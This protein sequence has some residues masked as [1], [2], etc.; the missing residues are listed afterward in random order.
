MCSDIFSVS[1]SAALNGLDDGSCLTFQIILKGV[2]NDCCQSLPHSPQP[3]QQKS[4]TFLTCG[5]QFFIFSF[6]YG[7]RM[8]PKNDLRETVSHISPQ[9]Q[10]EVRSLQKEQ[11]TYIG[12]QLLEDIKKRIFK[13]FL[14]QPAVQISIQSFQPS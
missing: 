4:R 12:I 10:S 8:E 2:Q 1:Q 3:Q 6:N 14:V 9:L 11:G 13:S 7:P 5:S